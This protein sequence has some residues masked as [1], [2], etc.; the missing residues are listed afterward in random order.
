MHSKSKLITERED[1]ACLW[2]PLHSWLHGDSVLNGLTSSVRHYFV[3]LCLYL[4]VCISYNCDRCFF[5][6]LL[7]KEM[8][9]RPC[10]SLIPVDLL[11]HYHYG[12]TDYN[13]LPS[14]LPG[15]FVCVSTRLVLCTCTISARIQIT[16]SPQ[17][18]TNNNNTPCSSLFSSYK[19]KIY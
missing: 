8:L 18:L 14:S 17:P 3:F 9:V 10:N 13:H 5:C 19:Q 15:S 16:F 12:P 2:L 7:V 1:T 6:G 4:C 11:T